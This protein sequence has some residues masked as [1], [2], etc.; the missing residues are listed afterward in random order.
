MRSETYPS[1]STSL[2]PDVDRLARLEAPREEQEED[3][4]FRLLQEVGVRRVRPRLLSRLLIC[5]PPVDRL[6]GPQVPPLD[7]LDHLPPL[8]VKEQGRLRGK[9]AK[10]NGKI[11]KKIIISTRKVRET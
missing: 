3:L 2:T 6:R 4:Q 1:I 9:R 11:N 7:D 10:G 8:V 5:Q